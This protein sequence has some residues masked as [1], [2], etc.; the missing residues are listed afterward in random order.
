MEIRT[1]GDTTVVLTENGKIYTVSDVSAGTAQDVT[2]R[3]GVDVSTD[4]GF[5]RDEVGK[6]RAFYAA[7]FEMDKLRENGLI[8]IDREQTY[9]TDLDAE[10]AIVAESV[11]SGEMSEDEADHAIWAL[12]VIWA[13][14]DPEG[15]DDPVA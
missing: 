1:Y 5:Y 12:R 2:A 6:F 11:L 8:R 9:I 3:V 13:Y 10:L 4:F 15:N 14:L 7:P